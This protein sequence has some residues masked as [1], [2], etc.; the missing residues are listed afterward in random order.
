MTR[1]LG[2]LF[3]FQLSRSIVV[4]WAGIVLL[5]SVALVVFDEFSGAFPSVLPA[6]LGSSL[7]LFG[8]VLRGSEPE[9]LRGWLVPH[10]LSVTRLNLGLFVAHS[11]VPLVGLTVLYAVMALKSPNPLSAA[12]LVSFVAVAL[13]CISW[14]TLSSRLVPGSSNV[15]LSLAIQLSASL[16]MPDTFRAEGH[17]SQLLVLS[18]F[19]PILSRE[20]SSMWLQILW[21]LLVATVL[22]FTA[23]FANRRTNR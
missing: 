5:V 8:G 18:A 17:L 20:I 21:P 10:R 1:L 4:I 22:L 14:T 19:S 15:F 11:I 12:R 9:Q 23:L 13:A 2:L 7:F 16:A 6:A 3:A